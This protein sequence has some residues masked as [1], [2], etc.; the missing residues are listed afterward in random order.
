[1]NKISI[2]IITA[3][4]TTFISSSY[5]GG[6]FFYYFGDKKAMFQKEN[7]ISVK[8]KDNAENPAFKNVKSIMRPYTKDEMIFNTMHDNK[9]L[10][11]VIIYKLNDFT[12]KGIARDLKNQI[13]LNYDV[14]SVGEAYSSGD[15]VLHFTTNEIIVKFKKNVSPA[16]ISSLNLL[17]KSR[18][19]EKINSFDNVYLITIESN[20]N[21]SKDNVFDVSNKFAVTPFVEFA[22]PNFI[23]SGMLIETPRSPQL[24]SGRREDIPPYE[25]NFKFV[26]NDTMLGMMWHI[27]NTGTNFQFPVPGIPGSDANVIPAW[28]ITTGNPSVLIAI[29]DTGVDTNHADLKNQLCDRRLWYDAYDNDQKP[30]DE[31]YHGTGVSGISCAEGNNIA[32]TVGVAYGCKEMPVRVFGPAPQAFTTDLILAKGLNWAWMHGASVINCSWGGGIPVPIITHAIQNAV[33]SGRSGRGTVVVGGSGNDDIDGVIYPASLDEV[34]GAGGLSPC[35]Q[36]KSKLSCDNLGDTL[37]NWGACYGEGLEVVAPCVFIGTTMLFGDW[38]ICGTGTS[39][40][41]PLTAAIAGLIL[42]KNNTLSGD[43]VY[44]IICRSAVKMGSYNY[45][46]PKKY[47]GWNNEVGYGR[48]DARLALDMTTQGPAVIGDQVPPIINIFPP[49]SKIFS[50]NITFT[51]EVSDL[52]GIASGNNSPKLYYHTIQYPGVVYSSNGIFKGNNLY[53]FSFPTIPVSEGFSYYIAA[54]DISAVP[55]TATY[56]YGGRGANPPGYNAPPKLMFVRN[57]TTYDTTII[58]TD[59]PI[60]IPSNSTSTLFSVL[61]T[62]PGKQVLDVSCTVNILHT[63]TADLTLS[64]ISPQGTEIVLLSGIGWDGDSLWNTTLDDEANINIDDSAA[65]SP[66]TG[67]Y[68]PVEKLWFFDGEQGGGQWKM[69]ICDNGNGDGGTLNAWSVNFKFAHNDGISIPGSFSLVKN[70]PNPFNP[71]TRIIFNVPRTAKIKIVLYDV[72]GREVKTLLNETRSAKLE[73]YV[74]FDASL[75]NGGNGLASGV[76]FY[77]MIADDEFI[78]AKRMVLVK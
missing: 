41:S 38:C 35:N 78:D 3:V 8:F 51:A 60:V 42:S 45:G 28:D 21:D 58:S 68:K 65:V 70:Y 57:T 48:V 20:G 16:D 46:T 37:Q 2:I 75:F 15:K 71:K 12:T 64:L 73:D 29:V 23:R 25:M 69:K 7:Y 40:S 62:V 5:S 26:P 30:Q 24:K 72:S 67:T 32:G 43:S 18:I 22:Q 39:D 52:N 1:M 74:D 13:L 63:F 9:T 66:Y 59:V 47:G 4:L 44:A 31:H 50:S 27:R 77:N 34:I 36:R 49:E 33:I 19:E 53:E 14:E 61:N 76:Y 55:N 56:P 6:N 11:K 54:Q 17:Y 10:S